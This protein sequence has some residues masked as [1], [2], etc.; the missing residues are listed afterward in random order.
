[1]AGAAEILG[2]QVVVEGMQKF[3]GEMKSADGA[4]DK[5]ASGW[6]KAGGA[7]SSIAGTAFTAIAAGA[8]A[9][10]AAIGVTAVAIAKLAIDAAPLQGIGSA[11][12]AMSDKAGVSLDA[13]RTA[14]NGTVSD[15]ELMRMANVALTGAGEDFGKE[16]GQNLPKLLEAARAA[17]KATGQDV[18]FLFNSLVT[19]IKRGSPMLIDNTGLVLKLGEANEAMAKKL[20]KSVDELTAEEKQ[21]AILNATVEA[22]EKMVAQFGGGQV[23]ASEQLAQFKAQIQNTKDQIG[24]AFIPVLQKVMTPILKLAETALPK[25][26]EGFT[27]LSEAIMAFA[28]G[29]PGDYPWEDILPESLANVAYGIAA[30]FEQVVAIFRQLKESFDTFRWAVSVGVEPLD[31]L[32]LALQTAFGPDVAA[33][34]MGFIDGVKGAIETLRPFIE[35][36]IPMFQQVGDFIVKVWQ[37]VVAFA[38]PLIDQIAAFFVEKIGFIVAWAQT[39]LPLMQA[40]FQTVLAAI[41]AV[42]NAVWPA[43]QLVITEVWTVIQTV[44]SVALAAITAI[45]TAVMLA[46]QGDWDTAWATIQTAAETIWETIKTGVETFIGNVATALGTTM[47]EVKASWQSAWDSL[48]T[49]VNTIWGKIKTAISESIQK[50]K[51]FFTETDWGQVGKSI[52]EGI[53]NGITSAAGSIA[54]AAKSAAR[55]ALDAAKAA[56]GIHS[57]SAVFREQIGRNMGLGIAAGIADLV[58]TINAQIRAVAAPAGVGGSNNSSMSIV[59]NYNLTTN[60]MTRPG[61]LSLEFAAMQMGSR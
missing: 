39:N 55:A 42:W 7:I 1:M 2:L 3:L 50:I 26:V 19:G 57:P 30:A 37:D 43:I 14:A 12:E 40:T 54:D 38:L 34:V 32:K 49:I 45:I 60:A 23:S 61:G 41:Q 5:T 29:A 17:A 18:G 25:A 47:E 28:S 6:S 31:A 21:I 16:F 20:G 56:L 15:F 33:T 59:N 36:A 51:G 58:P 44:V 4:V 46:I 52:I 10:A 22:G 48:V 11:F 35:A 13:L 8:V 9:A 24:L 27:I 53:A